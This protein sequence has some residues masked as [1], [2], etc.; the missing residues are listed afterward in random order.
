MRNEFTSVIER[1]GKRFGGYCQEILGAEGE[2]M[3]VEERGASLSAAITLI[4]ED[5]R[6]ES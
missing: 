1:H 2:G 4:L 5:R 6:E 3:T